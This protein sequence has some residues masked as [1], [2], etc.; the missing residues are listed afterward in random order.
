MRSLF[1]NIL[2]IVGQLL[3]NAIRNALEHTFTALELYTKMTRIKL[4]SNNARNEFPFGDEAHD[5]T[6]KHTL[7][8]H[9]KA[10]MS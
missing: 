6:C 5:E 2:H 4:Q 3:N 8:Q 10:E 9:L 1:T 7:W